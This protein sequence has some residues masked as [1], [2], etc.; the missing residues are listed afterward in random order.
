MNSPVFGSK[1][2]C[3]VCSKSI[4]EDIS[5][6]SFPAYHRGRDGMHN[7]MSKGTILS[8]YY[9]RT[10]KRAVLSDDYIQIHS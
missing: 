1:P 10:H 6:L 9:T 5:G 7:N 2:T 4:G 3:T 8:A